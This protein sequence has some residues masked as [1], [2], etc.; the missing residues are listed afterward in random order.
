MFQKTSL[1]TSNRNIVDLP[2]RIQQRLRGGGDGYLKGRISSQARWVMP[3][4]PEFG[5]WGR[6]IIR[7][8]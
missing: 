1:E 7:S 2:G 8:Y 3:I 4:I 6:R 5:S